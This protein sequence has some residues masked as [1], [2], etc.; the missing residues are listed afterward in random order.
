MF[1]WAPNFFGKTLAQVGPSDKFLASIRPIR[2]TNSNLKLK[3]SGFLAFF[4]HFHL[5]WASVRSVQRAK[6]SNFFKF[7]NCFPYSSKR[8]Q[9]FFEGYRDP[10]VSLKQ[11]W[12]HMRRFVK[13]YD[14]LKRK[15]KNSKMYRF[16]SYLGSDSVMSQDVSDFAT[17]LYKNS[18]KLT[19]IT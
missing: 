8:P 11:F 1:F 17:K 14:I 13:F 7:K 18:W 15:K 10:L 12:S 5:I 19:H 4:C 2:P 6:N 16:P 3:K 9:N